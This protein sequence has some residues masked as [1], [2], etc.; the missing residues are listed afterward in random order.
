MRYIFGVII[1]IFIVVG[2]IGLTESG[3]FAGPCERPIAYQLGGIDE[4]FDISTSTAQ[5]HLAAAESVW[6]GVVD[7]ELF[8]HDPENAELSVNF[9]FDM[10]QRRTNKVNKIESELAD[11]QS[12][13]EDIMAE[14]ER[15]SNR[16][17]SLLQEYQSRR[18]EYESDLAAYNERV[19]K[20]RQRGGAPEDV[21]RELTN[22]RKELSDTRESLAADRRRLEK[23][24]QDI[25]E[26]ASN[27]NTL[28][29]QYNQTASTFTER[30]GGTREF[31]QAIYTG[32]AINVYQFETGEDLRL[33]LAHEFGHALGI[34]HVE[35]SKSVMYY[36]MDDQSLDDITLSETDISALKKVCN[37]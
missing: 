15:I 12:T 33:A 25:N 14:Y 3:L 26:L 22:R 13:H 11:I 20:W 30:F 23:L 34:N 21:H 7:K 8:V 17:D 6:E 28:A 36:L 27:G 18:Q 9:I 19:Q 35:G 37:S 1:I 24:R 32:D 5:S 29:R 31:N 10:R 2:A 16:Y 4:E